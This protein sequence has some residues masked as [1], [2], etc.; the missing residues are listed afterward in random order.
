MS[1]SMKS[2]VL[3]LSNCVA[4]Y[5]VHA[6]KHYAYFVCALYCNEVNEESNGVYRGLD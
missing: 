5:D 3:S 1:I 6:V 2:D 4:S